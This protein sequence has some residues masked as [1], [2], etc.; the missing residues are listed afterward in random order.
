MLT[1][2]DRPTSHLENF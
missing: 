1:I 2:D